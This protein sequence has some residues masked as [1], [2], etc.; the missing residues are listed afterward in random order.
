MCLS[1][2]LNGKPFTVV[3]D[4]NQTR[5][6]TFVTDIVN[7]CVTAAQT[8]KTI[9]EV[10]NVGSNNTYSINRL[11]ELFGGEVVY[12]PRRPGEPDCTFA[13][14]NKIRSLMGWK[15]LISFEDGVKIMLDHVDDWKEA[16]IWEPGSISKA[17]EGWFKYLGE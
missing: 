9:G 7:A 3:G 4:G 6:F 2:K 15:T 13:D 10:M 12:I 1:Q 8:E 5:D 16:P 17:T 11:V 14:I